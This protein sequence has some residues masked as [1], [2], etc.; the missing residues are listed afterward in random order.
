MIIV[1]ITT[2]TTIVAIAPIAPIAAI[3]S[4]SS[5]VTIIVAQTIATQKSCVC[6]MCTKEQCQA[7]NQLGDVKCNES[8]HF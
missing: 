3:E 1:A 2:I 6:V 5:V 4:M 8:Q 7:E